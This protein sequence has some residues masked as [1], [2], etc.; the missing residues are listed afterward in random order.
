MKYYDNLNKVIDTIE[1]EL[2]SKIEYNELAKIV[3]ISS[4]SLQRTFAF[5]TGMTL[6][7]YIRKRRLSKAAEEIKKTDEKI[8]DIAL[9]YQYDS[10][11]SFSNAFKKM[12]GISPANARKSNQK[13]KVFDKIQFKPAIEEIKEFKYRIVEMEEQEFYGVTTGKIS[14]QNKKAIRDL[15]TKIKSDGTMQFFIKNFN[16]EELYYGIYD[17]I[18]NNG[19][20]TDNAKY[21]IAGKKKRDNLEKIKIPKGLWVCFTLLNKE[22]VDIIKLYNYIYTEWLPSLGNRESIYY[23]RLEIYYKD[24]CEICI[25][26]ENS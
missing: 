6:T 1:K 19:E 5:L 4:Y 24:Y 20:Y 18:I 13:L 26:I 25:A 14:N 21:Y 16:Q 10:P 9:K 3:G 11:V 12:H 15:Y 7:E 2:T 22:Q 23:P 8:I 17:P